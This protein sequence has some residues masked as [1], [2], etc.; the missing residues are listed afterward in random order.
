MAEIALRVLAHLF[1]SGCLFA[2]ALLLILLLLIFDLFSQLRDTAHAHIDHQLLM[3]SAHKFELFGDI[4]LEEFGLLGG[5]LARQELS[6]Q[7][8]VFFGG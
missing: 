5:L 7:V 2:L 6:Q 1:R 8:K 4:L 3:L